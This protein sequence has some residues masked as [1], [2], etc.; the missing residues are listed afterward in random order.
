LAGEIATPANF[1]DSKKYL[2]DKVTDLM[3][4]VLKNDKN[5]VVKHEA[6][7]QIAAR[8]MRNNIPD[9]VH[10]FLH[11]TSVL[12]RHKAL[13]SLGLMRAT[14]VAV[15]IKNCLSEP[16]VDVQETTQFVLKRL[17]RMQELR[18]QYEQSSIL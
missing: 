6:C 14:E 5:S 1:D 4:W 8:N 13:E 3:A 17:K 11:N 10:A 9:L 15:I 12:T 7:Y 16:S 2:F 18:G